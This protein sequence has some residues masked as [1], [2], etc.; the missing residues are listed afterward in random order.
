MPRAVVGVWDFSWL[1]FWERGWGSGICADERA[2]GH[3]AEGCDYDVRMWV[4]VDD[5]GD[6]VFDDVKLFD[7]GVRFV[8]VG[9][10]DHFCV[11]INVLASIP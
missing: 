5:A 4:D 8:G 7:R 2:G 9:E 1:G 6:A 10:V 3:G 11:L